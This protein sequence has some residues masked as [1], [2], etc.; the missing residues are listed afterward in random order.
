MEALRGAFL[1]VEGSLG[2]GKGGLRD[3][4]APTLVPVVGAQ[5]GRERPQV[6]WWIEKATYQREES[7]FAGWQA[8]SKKGKRKGF[9]LS[10]FGPGGGGGYWAFSCGVGGHLPFG[11]P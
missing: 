5:G 8:E 1:C 10:A 6:W 3:P 11:M 7:I 2:L 4:V 9:G